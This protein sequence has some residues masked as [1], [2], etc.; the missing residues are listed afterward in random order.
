MFNESYGRLVEGKKSS[1]VLWMVVDTLALFISLCSVDGV[2]VVGLHRIPISACVI[3]KVDV[4][5]GAPGRLLEVSLMGRSMS[6]SASGLV[7]APVI[8]RQLMLKGLR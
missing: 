8:R 5:L 1:W 2:V 4:M 3:S 7:H 6:A